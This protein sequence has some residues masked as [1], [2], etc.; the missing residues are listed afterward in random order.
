MKIHPNR[1]Y[2]YCYQDSYFIVRTYLKNKKCWA[3]DI[4]RIAGTA[5]LMS[6]WEF[7]EAANLK[8]SMISQVFEVTP[9]THPHLFI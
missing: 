6:N 2:H 7:E 8:D 5:E 9:T 3:T 4:Q 1:Y